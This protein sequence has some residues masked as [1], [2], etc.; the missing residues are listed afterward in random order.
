MPLGLQVGIDLGVMDHFAEEE[1]AAAGIFVDGAEGDIDG[2]F[3]AVTKSEMPGEVDVDGP[4]VEQGRGE[5]L[6][7]FVLLLTPVLDSGDQGAAIDDGISKFFI[8]N[9]KGTLY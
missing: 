6:F 8:S 9:R 7:H 3:H 2:V 1:D 4:E 5:I